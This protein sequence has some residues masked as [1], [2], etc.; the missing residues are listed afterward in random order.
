MSDASQPSVDYAVDLLIQLRSPEAKMPTAGSDLAAGIDLYA[1]E[2]KVVPARGKA[3]IDLGMSLAIPPGHYGRVAPRSGLAS[4][5]SIQTGAGVI[6]ADYRGP[7][8]VLL[9]NHSDED[10]QVNPGDR[11]AQL[12]LERISVPRL[13]QVE[14]LEETARG[15]GGFGST[16]GFG[17]AAKKQKLENGEGA[18][19][20]E[21][22]EAII[23]GTS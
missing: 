17:P 15:S 11:I 23:E 10:F 21:P 16:G 9:F 12:I 13:R 3:L 22:T 6:D 5:H 19:L 18:V 8:M 7:L 1:A 14:S 20:P 2:S 4:K